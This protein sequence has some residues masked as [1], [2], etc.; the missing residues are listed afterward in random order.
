[1]KSIEFKKSCHFFSHGCAAAGCWRCF[2]A[3]ISH[4]LG[5]FHGATDLTSLFSTAGVISVLQVAPGE[6]LFAE[7]HPVA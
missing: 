5:Q 4:G 6:L 1:M 2:C 3:T 7:P